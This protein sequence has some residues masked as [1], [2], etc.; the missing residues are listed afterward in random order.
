MTHCKQKRMYEAYQRFNKS[1]AHSIFDV[2][3][4]PSEAKQYAFMRCEKR[5]RILK[6]GCP[7]IIS[8]NGFFFSV[9]FFAKHPDTDIDIFVVITPE[10]EL[11]CYTIELEE[12]ML[13]YS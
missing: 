12:L 7:Y 13:K 3:A 8:Y 10:K 5:A 6:G 2:Y 4:K 9:A 11:W 1:T